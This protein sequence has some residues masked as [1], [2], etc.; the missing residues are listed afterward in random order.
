MADFRRSALRLCQIAPTNQQ[1]NIRITRA[2]RRCGMTA[3]I[4]GAAH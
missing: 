4:T 3:D 2:N 1:R